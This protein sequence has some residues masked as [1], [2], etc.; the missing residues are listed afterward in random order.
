MQRWTQR[1][2]FLL[3]SDAEQ[4]FVASIMIVVMWFAGSIW[5]FIEPPKLKL[6]NQGAEDP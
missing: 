1:T 5:P 2:L 3:R 6:A 4:G